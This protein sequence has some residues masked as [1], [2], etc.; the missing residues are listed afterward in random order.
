MKTTTPMPNVTQSRMRY[1]RGDLKQ[2]CEAAF[3]LARLHGTRAFVGSN[4]GGYFVT[5][6]QAE[7]H[8]SSNVYHEVRP[9]GQVAKVEDHPERDGALKRAETELAA[10][11][12]YG[13]HYDRNIAGMLQTARDA[14]RTGYPEI[15]SE[16]I[17]AAYD[18]A[19]IIA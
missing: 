19:S 2:A 6:D 17:E 14:E 15:A 18:V 8:G 4:Y 1:D 3:D 11:V 5:R 16:A 12:T 10:Y 9:T 13:E 7:A